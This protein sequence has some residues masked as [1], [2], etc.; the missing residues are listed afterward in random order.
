MLP[1]KRLEIRRHAAKGEALGGDSLSSEGVARAHALGRSIRIGFTHLYTSGAQRATQTLACIV[2]GMGRY[3]VNGVEV[4]PGLQ[5][6]REGEWREAARRAAGPS[7]DEIR[8][9]DEALVREEAEHLAEELRSILR[10][11]PDGSYAL[12][13]GHS[14]ITECA[15]YGLAG[16]LY[17]PLRPCEGFLVT[18]Q[19]GGRLEIDELR[20]ADGAG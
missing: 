5:S 17:A 12:A 1:S 16:K 11:L 18:E 6:A 3:V 2:A 14:P 15:I 19:R 4:R 10:D 20:D 7:I 13:I 8:K 9:V